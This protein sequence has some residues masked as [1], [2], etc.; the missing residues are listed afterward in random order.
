M[1]Q[2]L[3][4]HLKP[5]LTPNLLDQQWHLNNIKLVIQL[6]NLLQVLLLHPPARIALLAITALLWEQQLVHHDTMRVYPI[7]R[8]LLYH[9]LRLVQTQ[10]LG[11]AH[12]DK[13]REAV[14]LELRIDFGDSLTQRLELLEHLRQIR[15]VRQPA[16]RTENAIQHGPELSRELRDLGERLFK[17]GGK[18]EETEGVACRR[19]VE[20][21]GFVGER[22]YLFKNFGEGHGFVD[23]GDLGYMLVMPQ[24]VGLAC[25]ESLQQMRG[26]ASFLLRLLVFLH[27]RLDQLITLGYS[28]WGQS[29]WHSSS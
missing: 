26:L 29:P 9:S 27:R 14:V 8:Q 25:G 15:T 6:L 2:H 23:A 18:L 10:E 12:A 13:G 28:H 11:D 1:N 21:Y 7:A 19:G 4:K 20:D 3:T 5:L 16:L 22:F 17:H 24:V